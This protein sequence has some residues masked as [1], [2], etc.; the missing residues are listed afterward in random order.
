LWTS[1][2]GRNLFLVPNQAMTLNEN[3]RC[4][5]LTVADGR[6]Y[7]VDRVVLAAGN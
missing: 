5:S 6:Y 1:G 4:V 2:K 7:Q 3:L